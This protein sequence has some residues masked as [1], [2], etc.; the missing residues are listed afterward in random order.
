MAQKQVHFSWRLLHLPLVKPL[1][2]TLLFTW[3]LHI[4]KCHC[5]KKKNAHLWWALRLLNAS[6]WPWKSFNVV[7]LYM[8]KQKNNTLK[9]LGTVDI[10][11]KICLFFCKELFEA[12]EFSLF[13][14]L[15]H[16]FSL[17]LPLSHTNT[18]TQTQLCLVASGAGA[19]W[20]HIWW[21]SCEVVREEAEM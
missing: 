14:S 6:A 4:I 13:F 10:L 11:C 19:L 20:P 8:E 12:Y 2:W 3:G 9:V 15:P 16:S 7:Q 18:H 1:R 21:C 17:S 5:K